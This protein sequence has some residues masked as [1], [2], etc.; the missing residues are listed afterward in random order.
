MVFKVLVVGDTNCGKTCLVNRIVD[1]IFTEDT[2]QTTCASNKTFDLIYESQSVKVQFTDVA[3]SFNYRTIVPSFY[4]N[5]KIVL[6][7]FSIDDIESFTNLQNWIES[8][9]S[10]LNITDESQNDFV[11][12][13]L[14]GA[15]SDLERT[16]EEKDAKQKSK[17]IGSACYI[18]VS[19][20]NGD[21]F[22][23]LKNK[24]AE[25]L[26]KKK[27]VQPF[28]EVIKDKDIQVKPTDQGSK[29]KCC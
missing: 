28:E 23:N 11:P 4:N 18:E 2:K 13:I 29:K 19:S 10:K 14:V 5:A 16:V 17:D 9:T 8:L 7:V 24:I 1:D 25:L 12:M 15:K 3:G 26:I 20:F 27:V 22:V 6:L 21:N